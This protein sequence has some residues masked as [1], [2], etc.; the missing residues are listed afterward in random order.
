[1]PMPMPMP[2]HEA[3]ADPGPSSPS[4]PVLEAL[5]QA[6]KAID[7]AIVQMTMKKREGTPSPE[8]E[9]TEGEPP[10]TGPDEEE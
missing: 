3:P 8:E 9:A 6:Q 4:S 5:K 1:M 7:D 10:A 2:M